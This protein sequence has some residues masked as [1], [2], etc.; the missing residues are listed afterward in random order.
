M[1]CIIHI[2]LEFCTAYEAVK[3]HGRW[4]STRAWPHSYS[5]R[6]C[7]RRGAQRTGPVSPAKDYRTRRVGES[8]TDGPRHRLRQSRGPRKP[9][10][11]PSESIVLTW[12]AACRTRAVDSCH[13]RVETSRIGH[14]KAF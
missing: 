3:P 13:A 6:S 12:K 1:R 14:T 5:R 7:G 4:S 2:A 9:T 10:E 11:L 8:P